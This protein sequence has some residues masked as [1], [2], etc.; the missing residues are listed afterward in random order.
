MHIAYC[1]RDGYVHIASGEAPDEGV[2]LFRGNHVDVFRLIE[3]MTDN[4]A[5]PFT[6]SKGFKEFLKE[7]EYRK[8]PSVEVNHAAQEALTW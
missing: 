2:E 4:R 8:G 5:I 3:M 7:A 1:F 6:T